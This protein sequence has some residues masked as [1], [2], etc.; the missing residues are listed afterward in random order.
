MPPRRRPG[1]TVAAAVVVLVACAAAVLL[2]VGSGPAS[3]GAAP[4]SPLRAAATAGTGQATPLAGSGRID[5]AGGSSSDATIAGW[6]L[7]DAPRP[8]AIV[9]G[10]DTTE[11]LAGQRRLDVE[12]V[13]PGETA[14][15]FTVELAGPVSETACL[16]L[17]G[18]L[19]D[20]AW[21][22]CA[23]LFGPTFARRLRDRFPGQR[24]SA[25]VVDTRTGCEYGLRPDL[26]ITTASVVKVEILGGLL[27]EAQRAGRSLT[28][29]ERRNAE[30]MM[31]LSL[32][33][34]TGAIWSQLGGV[35]GM[36]ALDRRL[37]ATATTQA[38]AFGATW[39]TARDR[40][41]VTLAVL[42]GRGPLKWSSVEVAHEIMAGVHPAQQWGISAG[43]AAGFRAVSKNG[44]Y[45][46]TGYGWRVGSTGFV[47]DPD[48]GGYAITIMSDHNATQAAG[49]ALVEAIA[50]HVARSLTAG[51]A[52][53]RPF[54]Q[55]R[56]LTHRGGGSWASLT[57]RLGLPASRADDVRRIA[58]GDGP[59]T[60]QL[61]CHPG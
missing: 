28:D 31:Q 37:G 8:V 35:A 22:G 50:R 10:G 16:R 38:Q 29:R 57:R 26:R 61:V 46:M 47:A 12:L 2:S 33:P 9:V 42:D 18:E 45:P 49:I 5:R 48:G 55:V 20:C 17:D 43:V 39:S 11:G 24:F 58:G 41:T 36:T 14:W 60:G 32:N 13:A 3:E 54:E 23:D 21:I 6:V 51:P 52:A 25:H 15:G 27:L 34:E 4:A 53:E 1:G 19:V 44:F 7:A 40:T 30:A 56:C 59:L